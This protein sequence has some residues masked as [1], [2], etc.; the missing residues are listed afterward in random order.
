MTA[1]QN[2][3]IIQYHERESA[4]IDWVDED[5]FSISL[6]QLMENFIEE[7]GDFDE[8]EEKVLA[9]MKHTD[10]LYEDVRKLY[11][12]EDYLVLTDEQADEKWEEYLDNL[13]DDCILPEIPKNLQFYFDKE[14]YIKDCKQDGRGLT[15]ASYD[16]DEIEQ[17]IND[18]TYYIFRCN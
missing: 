17:E 10:G 15:L 3:S 13:V 18:T 11:E 12:N 16:S 5:N 14:R 8:D 7:E 2:K 6:S 4:F 1:E 9:L